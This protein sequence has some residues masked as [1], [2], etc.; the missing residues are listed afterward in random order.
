V[1]VLNGPHAGRWFRIAQAIDPKTY[2]MDS[3]MPTGTADVAIASGFVGET[4]VRNR[5]DARG[6]SVAVPLDL[7]GNHFGTRVIGNHLL[8]ASGFRIAAAPTEQ[9]VHWGWSHAPVFGMVIEGNTLEDA[10]RGGTLSVEHGPSIKSNTGRVYLSATLNQTLVRWT[11]GFLARQPTGQDAP[12]GLM[13][14]EP[15]GLDAGELVVT[16]RANRAERPDGSKRSPGVEV[17]N[18]TI[19]GL[20]IDRQTFSLPDATKREEELNQEYNKR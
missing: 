8:G 7:I 14:G 3:P 18:A 12:K 15:G 1:A 6:S 10:R 13:I 19:N 16:T 5:V 4:F 11:D 17:H 9:P 20:R 2:L